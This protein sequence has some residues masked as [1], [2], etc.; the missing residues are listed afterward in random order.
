[1]AE[2]TLHLLI[3]VFM[4]HIRN[5]YLGLGD[6]GTCNLSPCSVRI[7]S[8]LESINRKIHHYLTEWEGLRAG[9]MKCSAAVFKL[10]FVELWVP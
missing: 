9:T 5:H 10:S 4:N 6:R 1:M 7:H 8:V 2:R 3:Y